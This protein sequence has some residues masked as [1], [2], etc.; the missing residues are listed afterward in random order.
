MNEYRLWYKHCPGVF[1]KNFKRKVFL[2]YCVCEW[3]VHSN[4]TCSYRL[5]KTQMEI[6]VKK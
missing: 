3:L 2:F 4:S 5:L 6:D 1:S